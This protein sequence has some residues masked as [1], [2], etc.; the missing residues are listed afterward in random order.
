VTFDV[1]REVSASV[2]SVSTA[3]P[4]RGKAVIVGTS[5]GGDLSFLL[6]IHHPEQVLA[7]FP[8]AARFLPAWMPE[9]GRCQPG[10]PLVFVMHGDEDRT[11]PM[12]P[13]RRSADRLAGM[14]LRVEFHSYAGAAHS[15]GTRSLTYHPPRRARR[16]SGGGDAPLTAA[17]MVGPCSPHRPTARTACRRC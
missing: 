15:R 7:A 17:R 1:L 6:A 10:C 4:T 5:Y 3:Y 13:T 12:A 11:V 9:A 16:E 8:V 14:G 2:D